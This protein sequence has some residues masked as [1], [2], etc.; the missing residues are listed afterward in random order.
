[1]KRWFFLAVVAALSGCSTVSDMYGKVMGSAGGQ[2][3]TPLTEFKP[4]VTARVLW[5]ANIGSADAYAFSP[6]YDDG[7]VFVAGAGGQ[8]A[9]LETGTGR[10]VWRIDTGS[11]LSGGVGV[12]GNLVLVGTAKGEVLA[13]DKQGKALWKAQVTSEVLS[14]PQTAEGVVVVRS[15]DNRIFGLDAL[16]GKRKWIYQRANPAL[17]VRS[18]AGVVIHR[19]AVFAGFPGGKLVALALANG[20]VGWEATVAQPKGA[21]ELERVTDITS[22]PAVDDQQACAVAFQ[23][24]IACFESRTGN[25]IWARDLSS[26]AGLGADRRNVYVSD[27]RGAVLAFDLARGSSLWK[28]DKLIGRLPGAPQAQGGFVAVGDSQG[29]LHVLNG[30]DGGFAARIATDGKPIT[31]QPIVIPNGFVVQ[32]LNGGVYAIALR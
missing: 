20:A 21:T 9:R 13:F 3:T 15:G 6:A 12:G 26:N 14:P 10:A 25:S 19:S 31:A 18:Y 5:Q 28:Q 1:M 17:T 16:D 11:R 32:T 24:R 7:A 23:G 8:L 30:D 2:K 22:L 27:E 4:T 29:Y